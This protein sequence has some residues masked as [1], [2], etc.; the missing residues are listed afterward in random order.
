MSIKQKFRTTMK[1]VNG[2]LLTPILIFSR[3]QGQRKFLLESSTKSEGGRYSFIG[4]NPRKTYS[5]SGTTLTELSHLTNKTYSYEGDLIHSLKQVMPR[6][7]NHTE[8]PFTG[9]AI[10]YISYG[11]TS[12]DS[13]QSDTE[14][15]IPTV[16]F[17]I[18]DTLIIFDHLT[19]ELVVFHT[20]IEAEQKEP[21]ID[22]IIEQLLYATP[23]K[24]T[25]Y[26]LS[27][28]RYQ[29]T[30][31]EFEQQIETLQR[32]IAKND[33]TQVVLS[34]RLETEFD[35]DAFALYR[36]LRIHN[37]A[38]YMY[39]IEFDDHT[40]V[41][42]SPE[43]LVRVHNGV[44]TTKPIAGIRPRGFTTTADL[45][46]E[47]ELRSNAQEIAEHNALVDIAKE[48]LEKICV[49]GSVKVT[50]YTA[51][52]RT[53]NLMQLTSAVEGKLSPTLH[54]IDALAHCIP[55]RKCNR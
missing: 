6:I 4:A 22:A 39:Y 9:G 55:Y 16:N 52:I 46:I 30:E 1:K 26:S 8:Y 27:P 45:A 15:G 23:A 28:F 50:N 10:G 33:S 7:S 32:A 19:D 17:H 34:R 12:L 35:G 31:L 53:E 44:V 25:D 42:S 13:Q 41:G 38:S 21:N 40:I 36:K 24:S 11:A 37:Q 29:T 48:D 43:S 3:L 47:Q 5:G 49:A 2:D 18:Y 54:A 14:I 51:T 20:N